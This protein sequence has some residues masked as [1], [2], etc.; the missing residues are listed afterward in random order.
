[1]KKID[2]ARKLRDKLLLCLGYHAPAI[3]GIISLRHRLSISVKG[4]ESAGRE[5]AGSSVT[6]PRPAPEKRRSH[7][8]K[9]EA[10]D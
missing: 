9:E 2:A 6:T 10:E 4:K 1:M 3:E 8:P 5:V 7:S